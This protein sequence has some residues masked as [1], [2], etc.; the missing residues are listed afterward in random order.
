MDSEDLCTSIIGTMCSDCIL[1][2]LIILVHKV[3]IV[4]IPTTKQLPEDLERQN[5]DRFSDIQKWPCTQGFIK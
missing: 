2:F 1:L 4:L 5:L 3:T